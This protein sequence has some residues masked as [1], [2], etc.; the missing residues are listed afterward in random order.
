M[1]MS[2]LKF[3][4]L[5]LAAPKSRQDCIAL[6]KEI[7]AELQNISAHIDRAFEECEQEFAKI[8]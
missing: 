5:A 3:D 4:L 1:S 6:A 2:N 7:L 8:A